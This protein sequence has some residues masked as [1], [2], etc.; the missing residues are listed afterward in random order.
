MTIKMTFRFALSYA[1][2]VALSWTFVSWCDSQLSS[3]GNRSSG[4]KPSAEQRNSLS[5]ADKV[6]ERL[7][8]M[9]QDALNMSSDTDSCA[10]KPK[11]RHIAITLIYMLLALG[12][13]LQT[14]LALYFI[15]ESEPHDFIVKRAQYISDW[16]INTPPILGVLANLI[17]FALA[18]SDKA[19]GGSVED[20]FHKYFL[21]AIIATLIGGAIY[22]IN[23]MLTAVIH[24][25]V[26]QHRSAID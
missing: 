23:L 21:I 26:E 5:E 14:W 3:L 17:E 13:S 8:C 19:P 18:W 9:N 15:G 20:F 16:C 6:L 1:V 7:R 25:A 22:I 12:L 4:N 11:A 10:P 24:P 2:M